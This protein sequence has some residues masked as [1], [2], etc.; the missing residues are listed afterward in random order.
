[1][2]SYPTIL[3]YKNGL[4]LPLPYRKERNEKEIV[5]FV[6]E[7]LKAGDD[8]SLLDII[9]NLTEQQRVQAK[10]ALFYGNRGSPE[11][12]KW[13]LLAARDGYIGWAHV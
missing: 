2:Y 13:S 4:P 11:F 10:A 3:F 12:N 5:N 7:S 8:S 1:V 6:K 9:S